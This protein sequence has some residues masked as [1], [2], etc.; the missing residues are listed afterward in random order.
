ME[1]EAQSD[2]RELNMRYI[3]KTIS[4]PHCGHHQHLN[5]DATAGDQ[6]Y[7]EDC[8]VCC[9]PIH[10]TMH[11]DESRLKVELYVDSDDEQIY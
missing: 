6:D 1:G 5:I 7:Y 9:N 4:C 2:L 10:M 11:I 3:N 8:R